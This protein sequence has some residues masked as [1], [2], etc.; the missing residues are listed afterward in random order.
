M[1]DLTKQG[2]N[3]TTRIYVKKRTANATSLVKQLLDDADADARW[4][5]IEA[6]AGSGDADIH[7][8]SEYIGDLTPPVG[9]PNR[10]TFEP[11]GNDNLIAKQFPGITTPEETDFTVGAPNLSDAGCVMLAGLDSGDLLDVFLLEVEDRLKAT[12]KTLNGLSDQGTT[13]KYKGGGEAYSYITG[14]ARNGYGAAGDLR[15]L[16]IPLNFQEMYGRVVVP[17]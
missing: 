1:G 11:Y 15:T 17:D 16:I 9:S 6:W 4:A 13:V 7:D 5:T 10:V 14:K 8:I 2:V 3:A 12:V